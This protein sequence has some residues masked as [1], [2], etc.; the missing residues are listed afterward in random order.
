MTGLTPDAVFAAAAG[1][2]GRFPLPH[3]GEV[4]RAG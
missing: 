3:A 4:R 2:L 1:L